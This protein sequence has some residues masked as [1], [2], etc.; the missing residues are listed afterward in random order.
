MSTWLW[1][2]FFVVVFGGGGIGE[3]ARR[4]LRPR[5]ARRLELTEAKARGERERREA[6]RPPEPVC[7]CGHHLATH[8][9]DGH[10]H[11]TVRAAVAWGADDKPERYEARDCPCQRHVGPELLPLTFAQE[12]TDLDHR[13][14]TDPER[15]PR[16]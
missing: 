8:D 11:E 13:A 16:G 6:A 2:L 5:H 15:R 7:G 14:R 12:L 3:R 1:V 4:A 9:E 10:C